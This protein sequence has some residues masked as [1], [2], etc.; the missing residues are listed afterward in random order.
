MFIRL[1]PNKVTIGLS[2]MVL[3]AI[4]A[5]LLSIQLTKPYDVK[6]VSVPSEES[7]DYIVKKDTAKT[8]LNSDGEPLNY[9]GL[10][11]NDKERYVVEPIYKSTSIDYLD[12][13]T[14]LMGEEEFDGE[15]QYTLWNADG[16]KLF[17]K[18]FPH[19]EGADRIFTFYNK[20]YVYTY[21]TD[22][23]S[24]L[25]SKKSHDY[26][27]FCYD[28]TPVEGFA[29]WVLNGGLATIRFIA[30]LAGI[31]LGFLANGLIAPKKYRL[32]DLRK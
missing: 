25:N 14:L 24:T 15:E 13:F 5:V 19:N 31:I 32:F 16:N 9:T 8:Y 30:L 22:Y 4:I 21:L 26:E 11:H 20:N 29:K 27:Y 10:W 3:G 1:Q 18:K 7:P 23:G 2:Y 17:E 6:G 12:G 28:G